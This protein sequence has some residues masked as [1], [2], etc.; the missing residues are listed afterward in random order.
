MKLGMIN[1]AWE[2]HGIDLLSGLERTKEIGFDCVDIFQ[3]PLD[4]G[5][6]ERIVAI[7]GKCEELDL[8]IIS[9]VG[10][11]VG[12]IDFNPS[13]QN[14]HLDR[15]KRYL[16]MAQQLGAKNYLLVIGEYIW[17]KEVIPPEEQWKWGVE[18]LKTL[19]EYA[20]ERDLEI[21]LELEPFDM[22]LVNNLSEMGRFLGDVDVPAVKANIDISHMLLSDSK[23]EE[24]ASL[25]GRA[26][27]VHISDCDGKVH[28]DFPPGDGVVDFPPYLQAIKDLDFD[29]AISLELEYS[30]EPEK[31]VEW[32]TKAYDATDKLM[33]DIDLRG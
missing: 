27:H 1:S 32:V 22:A 14:F 3:D 12:L 4:P 19:G 29:G 25:R 11:S 9:V 6:D 30:P 23:P 18:H 15:C 20:A 8:P 16:D 33:Q 31:I 21:V 10:V 24:L 13:V 7:K 5:A 28:G 17:Q 26:G 2:Q